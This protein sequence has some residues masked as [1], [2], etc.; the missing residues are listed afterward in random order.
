MNLFKVWNFYKKS[1]PRSMPFAFKLKR[2]RNIFA[3]KCHWGSSDS[4]VS[5]RK[6]F[7]QDAAPD[8]IFLI[9]RHKHPVGNFGDRTPATATNFVKGGGANRHTRRIG[10]FSGVVH[11]RIISCW[12]IGF[13]IQKCVCNSKSIRGPRF[14]MCISSAVRAKMIAAFISRESIR[15]NTTPQNIQGLDLH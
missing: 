3:G 6:P 13:P 7:G 11:D 5:A 10:A 4:A 15:Q 1:Q 2:E 14:V 12:R 8:Q 9:L